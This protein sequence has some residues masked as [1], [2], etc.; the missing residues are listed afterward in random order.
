VEQEVGA[1]SAQP[2]QL[3][4]IVSHLQSDTVLAPR[5]LS[6]PLLT[7]LADIAQLHGGHVPLHGRLFAQWMHHAYP[8]ECPFPHVIGATNRMSSEEWMDARDLDS[9]EATEDEMS[10]LV[11]LAREDV[12]TPEPHTDALP[13]TMA[14]ELV[15]GHL[16]MEEIA[17][18]SI[19]R[20]YIRPAVAMLLI[21]SVV[22]QMAHKP[23]SQCASNRGSRA[24]GCVV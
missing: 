7:R 11:N 2:S 13:W 24:L 5:N 14:E 22:V 12:V 4:D 15:A 23:Q 6:G 18:D 21:A 10:T 9:A 20:Q 3:S 1:P 16:A 17:P 19:V 8:R